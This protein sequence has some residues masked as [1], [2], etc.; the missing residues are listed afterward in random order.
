LTIDVRG[1]KDLSF[2]NAYK[3]E[4]GDGMGGAEVMQCMYM[5]RSKPIE[6]AV[7]ATARWVTDSICLGSMVSLSRISIIH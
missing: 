4:Q 7:T 3:E 2:E 6:F 1:R 5:A